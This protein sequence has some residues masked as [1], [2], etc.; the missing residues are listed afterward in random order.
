VT[1][2]VCI[3]LSSFF[4]SVSRFD[5]YTGTRESLRPQGLRSSLRV[6]QGQASPIQNLLVTVMT[7]ESLA[8]DIYIAAV[9][10]SSLKEPG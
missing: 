10:M 1:F 6:N 2:E 5:Y 3:A 7:K 8:M 4:V 9:A